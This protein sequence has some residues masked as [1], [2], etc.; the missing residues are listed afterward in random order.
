MQKLKQRFQQ[1]L[2]IE[3]VATRLAELDLELHPPVF[4]QSDEAVDI[5]PSINGFGTH[6]D[7]G[8][9]KGYERSV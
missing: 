1:W 4:V 2:G 3:A 8:V 9:K 7:A 6:D 5:V